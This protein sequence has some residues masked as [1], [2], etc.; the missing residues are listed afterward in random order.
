MLC[1][2]NHGPLITSSNYW[3][4]PEARLGKVLIST[5]AGAIRL[6]L[7]VQVEGYVEDMR[8]A[9]GCAVS[10]GPWAQVGGRDATE[11]L[12][13]DT[14]TDPFT[15]QITVAAWDGLPD[16]ARDVGRELILSCWTRPRRGKPH[17]ALQRPCYYRLVSRIPYLRPWREPGDRRG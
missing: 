12:F 15:L 3:D 13:D 8:A 16:P 6:L 9:E 10:R 17:L 1:V 5:N 14:S 11:I 2:E 7:P 4:L